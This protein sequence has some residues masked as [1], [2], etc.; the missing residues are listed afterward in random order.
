MPEDGIRSVIASFVAVKRKN[1]HIVNVVVY[2][3]G[4]PLRTYAL[5]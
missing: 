1:V 5:H 2:T 4:A 3:A